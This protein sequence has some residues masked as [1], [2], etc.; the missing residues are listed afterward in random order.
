MEKA[1]LNAI[2][3]EAF[4]KIRAAGEEKGVGF[5]A[6]LIFEELFIN[7]MKHAYGNSS[8]A[9]MIKAIDE[10]DNIV[11]EVADCG[12]AFDPT[13]HAPENPMRAIGGRGILTVK[14]FSKL[15]EYARIKGMNITTV[16][17]GS[18]E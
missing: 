4:E 6:P 14:A 13:V 15:V 11:V 12:D 8:G 5:E 3:D 7:V 2:Y 10:G 16:V 17:V 9:I 1:E 18:E